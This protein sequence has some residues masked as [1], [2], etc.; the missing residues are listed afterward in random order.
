VPTYLTVDEGLVPATCFQ[1]RQQM[2]EGAG[3]MGG[4]DSEAEKE[5]GTMARADPGQA[6]ARSCSLHRGRRSNARSCKWRELDDEMSVGIHAPALPPTPCALQ[7]YCC[8]SAL[9]EL[10]C[11][12]VS[13]LS[14]PWCLA[15]WYTDAE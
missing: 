11:C 7:C 6:R 13:V 4:V 10:A 2:Q 9:V 1:E 5:G 8:C 14:L 15:T 12:S 3:E